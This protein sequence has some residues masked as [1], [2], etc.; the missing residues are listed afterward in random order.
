MKKSSYGN[1][2][3]PDG[4]IYDFSTKQWMDSTMRR[5]TYLEQPT[6]TYARVMQIRKELNLNPMRMDN[7]LDESKLFKTNEPYTELRE[8]Y[9]HNEINNM[10]NNLPAIVLMDMKLQEPKNEN[11]KTK[12]SKNSY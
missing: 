7:V 4:R 10:V 1:F 5:I 3:G 9:G 11:K 12:T 6:E 8:I 2:G